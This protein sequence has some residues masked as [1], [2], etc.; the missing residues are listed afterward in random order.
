MTTGNIDYAT[1]YFKYRNP[2]PINGE[3]VNKTLKRLKTELRANASG[4]DTDLGGGD[5]GYLGLVLRGVKYAHITPTNSFI[6]R[7]FP[8]LL[9]IDPAQTAAQQV[10]ALDTHNE[11]IALFRE[12]K[13]TKKY[14]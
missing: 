4:V 8:G 11:A 3:P 10:Q 5:H 7:N 6:P 13:N 14:Y 2:T 1:V 12:C 9:V